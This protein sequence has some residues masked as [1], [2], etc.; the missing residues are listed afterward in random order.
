MS[1]T[2]KAIKNTLSNKALRAQ[3]ALKFDR[4]DQTIIKWIK[5]NH[6]YMSQ[7]EAVDLIHRYTKIKKSEILTTKKTNQ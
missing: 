1:L 6:M 7:T 5:S 3:L 4:T 2:D